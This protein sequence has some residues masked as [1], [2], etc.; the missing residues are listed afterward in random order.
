MTR[1]QCPVC[2]ASDLE[3]IIVLDDYPFAGNGVVQ[4]QFVDDVPHGTLSIGICRV[5]GALFQADPVSFDDLDAMIARQPDLQSN[6]ETVVE[7]DETERFI[8]S[9]LR[10]APEK[11]RVLDVGCGLGQMMSILREKGYD[12]VG[13]DANPKAAKIARDRGFEVIEGRFEEGMFED[14]SFDMIVTRSVLDHAIDPIT[15]LATMENI[16]K[17]GGVIAVEVPNF[18][19]VL[20]RSGFG[21]FT[22][23][24]VIYWTTPVLRYALTIQGL[25][26]LGGYEES[27]IA[28]FGQKVEKGEEAIDPVPPSDEYTE[29]LIEDVDAFL[30]RKDELADELPQLIEDQFPR[31]IVVLGAGTPTVDLLYYTGLH[32]KITKILTSDES[33]HGSIIAGSDIEVASIDSIDDDDFDAVLVSSDR[34]QDELLDRLEAF[35]DKGGRVIRFKPDI[36]VI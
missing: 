18:G 3:E 17:P 24:H 34:R 7:T 20:K 26:L 33:R 35:L 36:E 12:V 2:S 25:D 31:G 11:G 28:M 29:K 1:E 16:L 10:Y 9:L 32:D 21:G 23:H 5:C 6:D 27:Y 4:T 19:R 8:E 22:P 30:E 13:V 14:E 15:L